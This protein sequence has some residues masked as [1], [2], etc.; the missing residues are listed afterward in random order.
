MKVGNGKYFLQSANFDESTFTG[1]QLN[2][3]KN[4]ITGFNTKLDFYNTGS[5]KIYLPSGKIAKENTSETITVHYT[6]NGILTTKSYID[7]YYSEDLELD[8]NN[9]YY[10]GENGSGSIDIFEGLKDTDWCEKNDIKK[11]TAASIEE[12]ESLLTID[13]GGKSYPIWIQSSLLDKNNN[14]I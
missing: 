2:L 7:C 14:K 12:Y 13:S 1:F 3:A 10:C 6:E 5:E 9:N 4:K 8:D 11:A